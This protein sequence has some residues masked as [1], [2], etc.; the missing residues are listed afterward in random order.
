MNFRQTA[1]AETVRT[2]RIEH[3]R[4][5]TTGVGEERDEVRKNLMRTLPRIDTKYFYDEAGSRLFDRT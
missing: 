4:H 5:R 3:G 2:V 1:D